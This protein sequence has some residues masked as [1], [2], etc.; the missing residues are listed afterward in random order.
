MTQQE[1]PRS[2]NV[3][4]A[5]V[6]LAEDGPVAIITLNSP[7]TRNALSSAMFEALAQNLTKAAQRPGV[8]AIVVQAEGGVFCAGHDLKEMTAH[9]SDSDGGEAF[10]TQTMRACSNVMQQIVGMPQPVIA[11]VDGMATAAGCQLVAACDL[12]VAGPHARFCTP[13]VNIGLFCSTP[14]V[15]LS[16]NLARKH[17][18]EMLL[19]G[20]VFDANDALRFGLVNHVSPDGA[21]APALAL[22]RKI[23]Q[24][25]AQAITFGKKCFYRQLEAPL[26]QAYEDASAVMVAN[27][28]QADAREGIAAFL[29]KRAPQWAQRDAS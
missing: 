16:R 23:A 1:N 2:E 15:A 5:L 14:A 3:A 18:M 9:R 7:E 26:S 22:A 10:F 11:A 8:R 12:A 27:M 19:T 25:S 21:R 24:K 6:T 13:G 17:A 28:L 29:E 20:D 4:R